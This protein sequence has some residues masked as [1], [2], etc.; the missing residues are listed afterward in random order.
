MVPPH[1][2]RL[3]ARLL[4]RRRPAG[5]T[6]TS[7]PA[8]LSCS[9]W[10]RSCVSPSTCTPSDKALL[11]DYADLPQGHAGSG[12]GGSGPAC[13]SRLSAPRRT[14]SAPRR[15]N[16]RNWRNSTS[17]RLIF[18]PKVRAEPSGTAQYRSF[19]QSDENA[20]S[21]GFPTH[22]EAARQIKADAAKDPANLQKHKGW[23]LFIKHH[24]QAYRPQ[25]ATEALRKLYQDLVEME[26]AGPRAAGRSALCRRPASDD[27]PRCR[28]RQRRTRMCSGWMPTW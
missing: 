24:S 4:L 23:V 9:S 12:R 16:A 17:R 7:P 28:L 18:L 11:K 26:F 15:T 25:E 22:A 10:S 27:P 5:R 3:V 2:L 19:I 6:T 13:D 8:T 20:V 1:Q 21:K 14:Q